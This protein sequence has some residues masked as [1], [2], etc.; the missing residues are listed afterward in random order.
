METNLANIDATELEKQIAYAK[1]EAAKGDD[2]GFTVGTAFVESMRNTYYK[3]TGTALDEL[4]D[5]AIEAGAE[6]IHV[7]FG[8]EGKSD[9]KPT[10]IAI[11]DNGHGIPTDM[12]KFA[13]LWGGTHREGSRN[14]FG[15]F[16]FGL[17]SASVNQCRRFSVFSLVEGEPWRFIALDLDGIRDGDYNDPKT[18][19]PMPPKPVEKNPPDWLAKE[20]DK[21]FG[22]GAFTHGTIIVWEKL[23]RLSWSTTTG[24]TRKLSEH[25][26]VTYRNYISR[27]RL[28]IDG[29]RVEPTDPL[30]T[31]PDFRYFD[32]DEDRATPLEPA[33]I[34]VKPKD[35]GEKVPVRIRYS[36][37]PLSFFST[38]KEKSATRGNQ[39]ERWRVATDNHG[40]L[41]NRMGRQIHTLE[42]TPWDGFE[43]W[44]ND[45]RYWAAEIDFPAELDE[46]FTVSNSKQGVFL[47]DRMWDLLKDAGMEKALHS[48]RKSVRDDQKA[49]SA[50]PEKV[51]A[52]RASERSLE[53]SD[54]FKK[55]KTDTGSIEREKKA[56]E[57]LDNFIKKRA[58]ESKQSEDD[59][60]KQFEEEAK[61]H[62]YRV[63]FEHLPG[64]PFFR[65]EQIGG[66]KVLY[67]NR[68]HR[69]F[70]D[71]YAAPESTRLIR[72]AL[73]VLLFVI[74]DCELDAAGNVDRK[75]FYAV[76]R[77]EWS[78]TLATALEMLNRFIHDTEVV[79]VD[80]PSEEPSA[81][82]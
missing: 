76:E 44:R 73:E 50:E 66:M 36:R 24:L 8:Y 6:T 10:S 82:Q 27:V 18:G 55:S 51:G 54:K 20:I 56:K 58:R 70:S 15:R 65:V 43:R 12:L 79:D 77:Q 39:N 48:L 9:K 5:N 72:A 32:L 16:G 26:G 57:N 25:F 30:F 52:K 60:R 31:T 37:M 23:D 78:N 69:F 38:D 59:V 74:G 47:S 13:V 81:A 2:W 62:P 29:V 19:R 35:G 68:W 3:H 63:E 64:A 34:W 14:G 71:I 21:Q 11:I 49:K 45:D 17:P 42:Q 67:V 7:C 80:E 40:I 1:K 46:E 22:K 75:T 28:G 53:E 4:V 41:V 33:E 61:A